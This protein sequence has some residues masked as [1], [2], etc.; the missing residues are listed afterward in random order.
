MDEKTAPAADATSAGTA[1]E[2]KDATLLGEGGEQKPAEKPAADAKTEGAEGDK[3]KGA[4]KQTDTKDAK[5]PE[6]PEKY[7]LKLPDGTIVDDTLMGEFTTLAKDSKFTNEAAQKWADLHLK[8]MGQALQLQ[9]DAFDKEHVEKVTKWADELKSA[10]DLEGTVDQAGKPVPKIDALV[11]DANKVLS[12]FGSADEVKR[13]RADL[14]ES[15]LGNH[16]IL[17]RGLAKLAQYV[18]DDSMVL[19][20]AAGSGQKLSDAQVL[21]GEKTK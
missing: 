4:D 1:G 2:N 5:P 18:G 13:L 9:Q 12:A 20:T 6:V 21:Y 17:V 11:A 19:G 14:N 3:G 8:A 16:P 15:G 10:K 7:D